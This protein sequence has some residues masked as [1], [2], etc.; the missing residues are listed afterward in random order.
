MKFDVLK[1]AHIRSRPVGFW[2]TTQCIL[3]EKYHNFRQ[4]NPEGGDSI[5]EL[6][7]LTYVSKHSGSPFQ[8]IAFY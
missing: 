4:S 6:Y 8:Y 2:G 5:F 1:T 7:V 3:V